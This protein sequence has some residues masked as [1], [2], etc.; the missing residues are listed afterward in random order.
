MEDVP[1]AKLRAHGVPDGFIN[2]M[3][4][5]CARNRAER[6]SQWDEI[7]RDMTDVEQ[8]RGV[9]HMGVAV[10]ADSTAG[11][12]GRLAIS[13][14]FISPEQLQVAVG[15]QEKLMKA[16]VRKL[17]GTVLVEEGFIK[18]SDLKKLLALQSFQDRHNTDKSL[19]D[20]IVENGI[21]PAAA[22]EE[23]LRDQKEAFQRDGFSPSLDQ[24][25]V[26]KG[27]INDQQRRAVLRLSRRMSGA[28]AT[29]DV[30]VGVKECPSCVEVIPLQSL[31]CPK[32]HYVLEKAAKAEDVRC[33]A[34]STLQTRPG[35]YCERC[36]CN[37]VTGR[38]QTDPRLVACLSCGNLISGS[39]PNCSRC[40]EPRNSS[41]TRKVMKQTGRHARRM[42]SHLAALA[43]PILVIGG[44]V[45]A[46]F[47][48]MD[49]R[50]YVIKFFRGR[51]GEVR[52]SAEHFLDANQHRD[53]VGAARMFH[54]RNFTS[55]DESESAVLAFQQR[56]LNLPGPVYRLTDYTIE[57]VMITGDT[58]TVY[59]K[60][61]YTHA[62]KPL[63]VQDTRSKIYLT[64]VGN[65]W[66]VVY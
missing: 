39:S 41:V 15:I 20:L 43:I 6:Y 56:T 2:L 64:Y 62:E 42:A 49:G 7:I 4:G 50:S 22:V 19:G 57:R 46:G 28:N 37:V 44:I 59:L 34:C 24:I 9:D 55:L 26:K 10:G 48:W 33:V 11:M 25:L 18:N 27:V 66:R 35:E 61:T 65:E 13:H 30:L 47:F 3:K 58:A 17:L 5:M 45:V 21:A 23:A 32:C 36:G 16:G 1:V 31:Q 14:G 52:V 60:L 38:P 12:L 54:N 51:E 53:Y 29:S 63:D 8:G 40:G